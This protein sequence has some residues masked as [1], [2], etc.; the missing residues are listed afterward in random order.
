[1]ISF[2]V[3]IGKHIEKWRLADTQYAKEHSWDKTLPTVRF[4]L[5]RRRCL[6]QRFEGTE[7]HSE[8]IRTGKILIGVAQYPL[9]LIKCGL[10][11]TIGE[12]W[13][14][15]WEGGFVK[16]LND[17]GT[18]AKVLELDQPEPPDHHPDAR[19][20]YWLDK[21]KKVVKIDWIDPV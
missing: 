7:S 9:Y 8:A 14:H 10:L 17:V 4:V 3:K 6:L 16:A 15:T 11:H 5:N 1:M 2:Q 20:I 21:N 19:P 12:L 18:K 13:W